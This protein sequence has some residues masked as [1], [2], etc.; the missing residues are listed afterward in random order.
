MV[1]FK[2]FPDLH[3]SIVN[4]VAEGDWV[5]LNLIA[6]G[7]HRGSFMGYN[8]TGNK[9]VFEE[10]FFFRVAA[11]KLVEAWGAV[12]VADVIDQIKVRRHS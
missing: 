5:A 12:N 6:T 7:T 3:Y 9:I 4:A 11:G 10:M 8:A 2:A 1:L